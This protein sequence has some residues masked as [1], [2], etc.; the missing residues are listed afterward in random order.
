MGRLDDNIETD[1]KNAVIGDVVWIQWAQDWVNSM[2]IS[3]IKPEV[4]NASGLINDYTLLAMWLGFNG[5]RIEFN[6][7]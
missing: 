1:L 7:D 5:L 2:Q 3:D 6:A 4:C